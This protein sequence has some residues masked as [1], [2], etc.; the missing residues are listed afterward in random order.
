MKQAIENY[1]PQVAA[2][3]IRRRAFFVWSLAAI[4]IAIWVFLILLAPLAAATDFS[5][6]SNPLYKF[7]SFICHQM[8]ER[9]FHLEN[10][11]FTVC[12][13]CFGIYSGLLGGFVLYPIFRSIETV[14]PFPRFWLFLAMIPA[15]IDWSLGVFGVWENTHWSRFL[16][17]FILGAAC[18]VFIVPAIVELAQLSANRVKLIKR[19][20]S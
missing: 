8:P 15:A 11:A 14:E 7:F 16:T 9:S 6:V 19:N 5:A 18:A 17:G 2:E 12:A 10:H 1:V 4:L 13:R 20:S 3:T